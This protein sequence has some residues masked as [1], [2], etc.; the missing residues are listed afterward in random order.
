MVPLTFDAYSELISEPTTAVPRAPADLA[1]D[2]FI[3]EGRRRCL[4]HRVH[5]RARWPG[6]ITRPSRWSAKTRPRAPDRGPGRP[7]SSPAAPRPPGEPGRAT[8]GVPSWRRASPSRPRPRDA[9]RHRQ[10]RRARLQRA[11]PCANCRYCVTANEAPISAKKT[12]PIPSEPMEKLALRK[13]SSGS[14]GFAVA[15]SR[16]ANSTARTTKAAKEPSTAIGPAALLRLDDAVHERGQPG[17]SRARAGMSS[18]PGFGSRLS[19]T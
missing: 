5:H 3:A 2:A 12:R 4:R 15:S 18:A 8:R 17:R 16:H 14:I 6:A 1:G 7:R 9:E 19:G 11:I 13:K 10:H